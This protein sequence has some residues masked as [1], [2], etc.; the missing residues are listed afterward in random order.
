MQRLKR[1]ESLVALGVIGVSLVA[2]VQTM[3]IP[4]SP[5]YAKVGPQV[6]AYVASSLLLALGIG[7]LVQ[8]WRGS[9]VTPEEENQPLQRKPLG[10]LLL[11]LVLNAGL[12]EP[13]GFMPASTLLFCCT[14][15]AFGSRRPGR[16][17]LIGMAFAALAYFGFAEA[18]GINIG[19]GGLWEHWS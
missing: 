4:V 7:L 2:F 1:P 12:I 5:A 9:W 6:M 16:D 11:G 10:W 19:K 13:L 8:A 18:L 14:A 15:R 3:L 17:I